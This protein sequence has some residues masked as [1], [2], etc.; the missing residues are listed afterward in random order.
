MIN[1]LT[2]WVTGSFS[3]RNVRVG[4]RYDIGSAWSNINHDH[5]IMNTFIFM[6]YCVSAVWS[7][8]ILCRHLAIVC[9]HAHA[10]AHICC[11]IFLFRLLQNTGTFPTP[12]AAFICIK[13]LHLIYFINDSHYFNVHG[14][15]KMLSFK[16]HMWNPCHK[17]WV[18]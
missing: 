6:V 3:W 16:L 17:S 11:C 15:S 9:M 12:L 1:F 5:N 10:R 7:T 4:S 8:I 14:Q 2:R 13:T 18:N